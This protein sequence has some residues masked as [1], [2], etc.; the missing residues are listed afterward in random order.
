MA[1]DA[2]LVHAMCNYAS[3]LGATD[4]EASLRLFRDA[5]A[6]GHAISA[7]RYAHAVQATD[8]EAAVAFFRVAASAGHAKAQFELALM[9]EKSAPRNRS[10]CCRSR[11]RRGTRRRGA[12]TAR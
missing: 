6:R 10:S 9:L 7:Y 1:A 2:G 5:G 4:P 11:P 8:P 3:L 12:A